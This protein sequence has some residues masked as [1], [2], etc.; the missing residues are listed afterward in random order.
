MAIRVLVS[1]AGSDVGQGIIKALK[2]SR[3]KYFIV[4]TDIHHYCPGFFMADK[5]HVVRP[6]GKEGWLEETISIC[7]KEAIDVILLGTD[8]EPPFFAKYKETIERESSAKI[9]VDPL[10]KIEMAADKWKTVEFLRTNNL[11]FPF[12]A[13]GDDKAQIRQLVKQCGFPLI[14]KPRRGSGSKDVIRVR[15]NSELEQ[16]IKNVPDS[17]VQ[18][19]L[20]PDDQE[21]TS[22]VCL[23]KEGAIAGLITFKRQL[24]REGTTIRA[25][26]SDSK[27]I[28]DEIKKIALALKPYGPCN[29]QLRL[30]ERGAIP[31]EINLRFSGTTA[32]RSMLGFNDPDFFVQHLINNKP[33]YTIDYKKGVVM[34]YS[35]EVFID[36]AKW[37]E[38][39]QSNEIVNPYMKKRDIYN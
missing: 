37:G 26:T 38:I 22:A 34:R 19:Y 36:A 14:V 2:G 33:A 13:L 3:N 1:G 12:T 28:N 15:D 27:M 6:A 24:D 18:E 32:I 20:S 4:A 17:I 8:P 39:E 7:N 16:A 30:T 9:I 31:F 11:N 5:G 10:E 29:I 23:S 25:I 21:Y 35:E